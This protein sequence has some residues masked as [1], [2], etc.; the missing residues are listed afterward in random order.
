MAMFEAYYQRIGVKVIANPMD[1]STFR[2]AM[3]DPEQALGYLADTDEGNPFQVLRS[4]FVTGQTWNSAMHADPQ[5]DETFF[6]AISM[7]D[8]EKRDELL[9]EMNIRIIGE[10]VPY[11]W[12]PTPT[13]YEALSLIHI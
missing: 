12:L 3:R 9:R 2:A 13:M 5:H 8:A 11:V 10:R 4:R 6:R 1:Y 7:Q